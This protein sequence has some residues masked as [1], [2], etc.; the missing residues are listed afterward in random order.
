MFANERRQIIVDLLE[1]KP[2]V[3][4]S[5]LMKKFS[6]SIETVR[7]DL[8]YLEK[9]HALQRVHG[10]AVSAQKMMTF[11]NLETRMTENIIL[12]QQL[13]QTALTFIREHDVLALDT[14]STANELIPLLKE[15]FRHL[16]MVTNSPDLFHKLCDVPGFELIQIGGQFLR[17]ERA[18]FGH[19]AVDMIQRLHFSKAIIFPSA[20]SLKHGI[21]VF[22]HELFDIQRAM[23]QQA[24]EVLI[25]ADSSKFETTATIKLCDHSP[26]HTLITN[27]N[28]SEEL[29][30]L[31]IKNDIHI[32]Y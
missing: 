22:V 7:R 16:T 29:Y 18:F 19:L 25:L 8:A 27:R 13:A 10:G 32:V 24:D 12:K 5:E 11:A 4:V 9:K 15:N 23:M 1:E 26:S 20:V 17:R 31:Y 3:T 14:G 28:L 6:V 30:N 21:G 2:S